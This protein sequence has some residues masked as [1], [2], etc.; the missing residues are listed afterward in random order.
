MGGG[1]AG[2]GAGEPMK[3]RVNR[4]LNKLSD[5][6]TEAMAANELE[7]IARS[8]TPDALPPFLSAISDTRPTDKTPLR[9][10]SL[11]LISLISNS[12]PAAA[13]APHLPRMLSAALRRL[14]D[15]DSS[16]RAACVDA[17]RSIAAA[18]PAGAV[19]G[20]L[21]RPLTDALL[22]EQDQ[23]AQISAALCLAA[24][25]DATG[26]YPDLAH[27]LQK[28]LPRLVK[29]V[30]SNA[31]KAKAPLISLLGSVAAAGGAA[32]PALVGVLVPCL[33]EFLASE[34]WAARKAA[35][36][37]LAVVAVSEKDLLVGFKSSCISS[38][39]SRRFDKV[40]IVRDSMNR[41][42]DVW[43]EIPSSVDS[44]SNATPVSKKLQPNSSP[45]ENGSDERH[46]TASLSPSSV[47]STSPFIAKKSRF[48]SSRSPPPD[49]SPIITARKNAPSIRNKKLSPPL[50]HKADRTKAS[51]WK[52]E[53]SVAN[54]PAK[55][56][57]ENKL[58]KEQGGFESNVRSRL[59]ARRML[60]EKNCE[61]KGSML[62]GLKSGARVVPC[63]E[64]EILESTA[65]AEDISNELNAGHKDGDLSLI[66]MQLV[67]IE[68]QQSSLLDLLQ[69][70]IGNSQ[71]GIHSLETRVHGLEMAL[72]EI[73]RDIAVPSGRMLNNDPEVNTCCRLPGTEFLS[74]K[75]WRRHEGRYSSRFSIS[76]I[77]NLHEEGRTLYKW[78][79]QRF[80][81]QGGVVVNPLAEINPQSRATAEITPQRMKSGSHDTG[82]IHAQDG[83][84]QDLAPQM[85][86]TA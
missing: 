26:A 1:G 84:K 14:R 7:S 39:E 15:P 28:L 12:H 63:Q 34:D 36:E 74:G 50:S 5:R 78:D 16:V 47:R 42:L 22:H 66:R 73:S 57:N 31:F 46:P 10:Q 48:S 86:R 64:N 59:E 83:R 65:E 19:A 38:F 81:L 41:M 60:F 72:D 9:R 67:Q 55:V 30:R 70:F 24:A 52:V 61:E 21:L 79:K 17:V 33:V 35:A 68:N 71:N 58:Q 40:K 85:I 8:L 4:C 23:N 37:A 62:V 43:K 77:Q 25:V 44:A 69:R 27:H 75:F 45:R 82:N 20:V 80:G 51:D 3:Q 56:V 13:I 76:D 11:R 49:A 29:L 53:I 32:A 18:A 6:D 54:T 2:A